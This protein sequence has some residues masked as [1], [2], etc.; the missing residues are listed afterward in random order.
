[1]DGWE[2]HLAIL[3]PLVAGRFDALAG[4]DLSGED[5]IPYVTVQQIP[6]Y[7]LGRLEEAGREA[8]FPAPWLAALRD[9]VAARR[10]TATALVGMQ[11][12]AVAAL[13]AAGVECRVLKGRPFGE[14]YYGH[15]DWRRCV[16]VDLLVRLA[17]ADRALR[18]L[19]GLGYRTR[20]RRV[21]RRAEG[22]ALRH[23][24]LRTEHAL[25]L[26]RGELHLDLHWRMRTAPAY[27]VSEADV[28][29][30]PVT[31]RHDG[32]E[33][34]ALSDEYALVLLLVSIAH[35]LGRCG[36]RLR[37]LLDVQQLV[38]RVGGAIDWPGFFARREHENLL[39]I[40]VNALAV[41]EDVF[42]DGEG[43]PSLADALD[44][45][46]ALR[47]P[48]STAALVHHPRGSVE[49]ALWFLRVYPVRW[50]RDSLY[51]LDRQMPHP[52]RLFKAVSRATQFSFRLA[53]H[54]VV[55]R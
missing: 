30:D 36:C 54:L 46:R 11:A 29:A 20:A 5:F 47:L 6:P 12:E 32:T 31:I 3:R 18:V 22:V 53:R 45:H 1:M 44:A 9:Y 42:R 50:G 33:C 16:D 38:R 39:G 48:T 43:C 10:G 25:A 26:D 13:D 17:D 34:L 14:R 7:V 28:W 55:R 21:V 40:C 41:V 35:D 8:L 23:H 51:W 2:R 52:G 27:R 37:H 15:A 24:R 4:M 19:W 49:N